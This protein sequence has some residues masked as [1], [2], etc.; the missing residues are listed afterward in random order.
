[1]AA[2]PKKFSRNAVVTAGLF[3]L[4]AITF[5]MYVRREQAVD[6][7]ASARL[8]SRTLADE[9]RLSSDELTRM[10]RSY[11]ITRD[12]IYRK[13]YQEILDVRE[14]KL[15]RSPTYTR[16]GW[17]L[18]HPRPVQRGVENAQP[19]ALLDLMRSAGFTEGE[20]AKLAEA[21]AIS[22]S[23]TGIE[24]RVM[25][26]TAAGIRGGPT[27]RERVIGLL[28]DGS[29][30]NTKGAI[31]AAVDDFVS[32][33]DHRTAAAVDRAQR[34]AA[35]MRLLFLLVAA[36]LIVMLWRTY[37]ALRKTMGGS[38]SEVHQRIAALGGGSLVATDEEKRSP[39]SVLAWLAEANTR[40][41]DTIRER[42]QSEERMRAVVES[43]L[44][45][46]VS[47]NADGR[48][49]EFNPAAERTFGYKREDAI[50]RTMAELIIPP[51]MRAAHEEGLRRF[52]ATRS[53]R[54]L[55]KRVELTA[56][57]ADGTEILVE[58]AVVRLGSQEPP[59]FTGFIRDISEHKRDEIR[60][61]E[62]AAL[63]DH[64]QDAIIVRGLD[65]KVSYWN[66]GAERLYGW[67]S[68]EAMGRSVLGLFFKEPAPFH[69][70]SAHVMK[71]G[72]WTG[73][74]EKLTKDGSLTTVE[75]RWTLVRDAKG[76]AQCVMLIDT[77]IRQRKTLEQHF[78]RAQRMESIGTLA[79]GIAHDLNNVLAPIM[80]SIGLLKETVKGA[81]DQELLETI[82]GSA[83]R[84][85]DMV[86]QVLSF[87][88]GVGGQRKP[89]RAKQL[90]AEIEKIV[91]D[92]F[93]K[94][95][96]VRTVI[97]PDLW[98]IVG[99][100][101]QLHQV[102]LNLC[103]NARDAMPDGG[104]IAITADNVA[105]ASDEK[106]A[107][108]G[109]VAGTYVRIIVEDTGLGIAPNV[110]D[111]IFDPFFT[112]KEL[113]KGTGLGLSTSIGILRSHGGFIRVTSEVGIGTTFTV[114]LPAT[115]SPEVEACGL[116]AVDNVRGHGETV[117]IVDDEPSI[118]HITGQTLEAFG[119]RVL[120]AANGTQ[121]IA[122]YTEQH[123]KI[124]VVLTDM[125]MPV[126]D[127]LSMIQV[128]TRLN[129]RVRI[130]AVSG[131]GTNRAA[132]TEASTA[133]RDYLSKPFTAET[134]LSTV[135]QV[136]AER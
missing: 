39:N 10:A 121:G 77:D 93:P 14:G 34:M 11:A 82:A 122:I 66:K 17:H 50:G 30:N 97:K 61:R 41:S 128:L 80:M 133:V 4:L 26:M 6:A 132:A 23:L 102:L 90:I 78:L 38:V 35:I 73:E 20:F 81:E 72:Y 85:A 62:Q 58:L 111:N 32:A 99:D 40:L 70:A 87:A 13:H 53:A 120:L 103:V 126:L 15:P 135:Q 112:T 101:T 27:A 64:A 119:Y 7:A 65:N 136:L 117:L 19:G 110:I 130:I 118:R 96:Q 134:L 71:E 3:V 108:N 124:A 16:G 91:S 24:L 46:I 36:A 100:H 9:M 107:S 56:L 116:P 60:L 127:G 18:H 115:A 84:G 21:K 59:V 29:Y 44:D 98:T 83:R 33:V 129:P 43:A 25:E 8:N 49:T 86:A 69:L 22:D 55:G 131:L 37:A 114:F 57:R 47:M 63:L 75:S 104:Q 95:I 94:N 76:A 92:T 28:Y 54:I 31:M 67:S 105:L 2:P 74:L 68:A 48:V 5:G 12:T 88:R 113:G 1:M 123:A 52:L 51:D 79:G 125:M 89:V 109:S 106:P 42:T 45:C